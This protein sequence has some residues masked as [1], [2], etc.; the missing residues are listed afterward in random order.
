MTRNSL[1][2]TSFKNYILN[3]DKF[4]TTEGH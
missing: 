4:Q 3:F 1:P 2:S